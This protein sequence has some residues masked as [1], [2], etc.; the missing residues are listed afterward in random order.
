MRI[1]GIFNWLFK[2]TQ[3]ASPQGF[4][5]VRDTLASVSAQGDAPLGGDVFDRVIEDSGEVARG[6]AIPSGSG[7]SGGEGA[8]L[9][10]G[11]PSDELK[12]TDESDE[13]KAS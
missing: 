6:L 3:A 1:M 2:K 5:E 12:K 9:P 11:Q 10:F 8:F 13:K 4:P 7:A